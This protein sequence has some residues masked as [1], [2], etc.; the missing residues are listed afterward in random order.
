MVHQKI[1]ILLLICFFLLFIKQGIAAE[2]NSNQRDGAFVIAGQVTGGL[3]GQSIGLLVVGVPVLYAESLIFGDYSDFSPGFIYG[4]LVGALFGSA[5]TVHLIGE[6]FGSGGGSFKE[7]LKWSPL[8]PIGATIGYQ[9]SKGRFVETDLSQ[10]DG[11]FVMGGQVSGGLLGLGTGAFWGLGIGG[12]VS[13]IFL[14]DRETFALAAEF[15]GA[16]IGGI[17]GCAAGVYAIGEIFGGGGGSFKET[18]KWSPL[19]P[20]GATI[21]YQ[22]SKRKKPPSVSLANG[23]FTLHLPTMRIQSSQLPNHRP[24]TD[25][26]V[27]LVNVRF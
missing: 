14:E 4:G 8:T 25:Y 13:S 27:R 5:G 24:Q 11:P 21:G 3:F 2:T 9:R 22:R 6:T 18:L 10:R 23:Q 7:T 17:F 20:I 1:G 26:M 19:T 16:V 12:A 15:Y